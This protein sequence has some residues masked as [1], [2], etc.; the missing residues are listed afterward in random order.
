[1]AGKLDE[2]Q[3]RARISTRRTIRL[4]IRATLLSALACC[5]GLFPA[6]TAGA[7]SLDQKSAHRALG[8]DLRYLNASVAALPAARQQEETFAASIATSCPNVLAALNALPESAINEGTLTALGEEIGFD[9]SITGA[10]AAFQQPLVTLAATLKRLPWSKPKTAAEIKRSVEAQSR[11][12][13]LAPSDLCGDARAIAS[14][15]ARTTPGPT[16]NFV[17]GASA[18]AGEAGLGGLTHALVT[19]GAHTDQGGIASANRLRQQLA[20]GLASVTGRVALKVLVALGLH[21]T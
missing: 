14:T 4:T 18:I 21:A 17:A 11:F 5:G 13:A 15:N 16:L 8:A 6:I 9:V 7:T 10:D 2:L 19:F 12:L 20:A 3:Y 1:M